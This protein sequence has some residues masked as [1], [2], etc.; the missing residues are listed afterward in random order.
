MLISPG[1]L[2]FETVITF[3]NTLG[4]GY[5]SLLERYILGACAKFLRAAVSFVLIV[6]PFAWIISATIERIFIKRDIWIY[7][8]N[9]S[10]RH[11]FFKIWQ[12]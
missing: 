5:W 3:T 4:D 12:E 9:L 10:G 11:N 2:V 1:L 8:E 7:F 6:C